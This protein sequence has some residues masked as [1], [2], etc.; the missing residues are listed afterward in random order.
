MVNVVEALESGKAQEHMFSKGPTALEGRIQN[1][2]T[3][4]KKKKRKIGNGRRLV[5]KHSKKIQ[6]EQKK[7]NNSRSGGE[8]K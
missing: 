7:T 8:E 2:S 1:V 6:P 3:K 4:A 5:K